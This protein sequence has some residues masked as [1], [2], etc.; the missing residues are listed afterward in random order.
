LF[1]LTHAPNAKQELID[2]RGN[3]FAHA[4]GSHHPPVSTDPRLLHV[5][6][7]TSPRPEE[8]RSDVHVREWEAV[9][10]SARGKMVTL[11]VGP[12]EDAAAEGREDAEFA[13]LDSPGPKV[14]FHSMGNGKHHT[15]DGKPLLPHARFADSFEG[16][17][18]LQLEDVESPQLSDRRCVLP[19][20]VTDVRH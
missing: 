2:V 1:A 16:A 18:T 3:G 9:G 12:P 6:T 4:D 7:S 5:H 8:R 19:V 15:S 13:G 20:S 10:H 14:S 11:V 17:S